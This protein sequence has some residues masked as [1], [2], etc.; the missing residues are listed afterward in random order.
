MTATTED[1]QLCI[2]DLTEQFGVSRSYLLDVSENFFIDWLSSLKKAVDTK[3]FTHPSMMEAHNAP[4]IVSRIAFKGSPLG[5]AY[6]FPV[7]IAWGILGFVEYR[8]SKSGS[9]ESLF[10]W[11]NS[12][13]DPIIGL[14]PAVFTLGICAAVLVLFVTVGWSARQRVHTR[15]HLVSLSNAVYKLSA[16]LK[17]LEAER[18]TQT[19]LSLARDIRSIKEE[20]AQRRSPSTQIDADVIT[21][22]WSLEQLAGHLAKF[23]QSIDSWESNVAFLPELT[24]KI[25]VSLSQLS[26][27]VDNSETIVDHI[28]SHADLITN[29]QKITE[30]LNKTI[31][32][33]GQ[34]FTTAL[35]QWQSAAHNIEQRSEN[36]VTEQTAYSEALVHFAAVQEAFQQLV[37]EVHKIQ[38]DVS[39][40]QH[41]SN[42]SLER[43]LMMLALA[44]EMNQHDG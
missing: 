34:E 29:T 18:Q 17:S 6:L 15:N 3:D 35:N 13:N 5:R 8:Y 42:K 22:Q 1:I 26:Q 32:T 27:T 31:L 24:E 21:I 40:T 23:S 9:Q 38:E 12:T 2:Q 39:F 19:A 14:G 4:G 30:S 41:E 10:V 36:L 44:D 11:W 37:R 7:I 20:T 28:S 25:S 16:Y 43:A 33:F